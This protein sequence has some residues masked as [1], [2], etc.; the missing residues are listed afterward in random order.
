MERKQFTFYEEYYVAVKRLP[1]RRKAQT[2]L[3]ICQ[4][5]L[6]GVK[7]VELSESDEKIFERLRP[8]MDTEIRQSTEGRRC[9]EYKAWRKSVFERDD[10]TCQLCGVRGAKINAHHKKRYATHPNLRYELE[11]GIT[12]CVPCHKKVHGRVSHE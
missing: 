4:Y 3:A 12:L 2:L 10:Y 8:I 1:K 7:T 11:N 5:C 6:Y 9:A